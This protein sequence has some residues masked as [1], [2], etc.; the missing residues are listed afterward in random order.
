MP[1]KN[2]TPLSAAIDGQLYLMGM[3]RR[4]LA[5]ALGI[6]TQHLSSLLSGSALPSLEMSK[7]I[8]SLV[9]IGDKKIRRLAMQGRQ[10]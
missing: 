8:A 7:R 4:Q 3:S 2:V 10:K 5:G 9:P 6:T 1:K